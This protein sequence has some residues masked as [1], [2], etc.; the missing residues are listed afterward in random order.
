MALIHPVINHPLIFWLAEK[1][2]MK[3][4]ETQ[5]VRINVENEAHANRWSRFLG[6]LAFTKDRSIRFYQ[7]L[8]ETAAPVRNG[9]PDT[10]HLMNEQLVW[11]SQRTTPYEDNSVTRHIYSIVL[12]EM[13]DSTTST[14]SLHVRLS[15]AINY[16]ISKTSER[17]KPLF[18][19]VKR[20]QPKLVN[21]GFERYTW[22]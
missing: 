9:S 14:S 21:R 4:G 11:R 18:Y 15:Q 13:G 7:R 8:S 5:R 1:R 10:Q 17:G 3:N 2:R 16:S 19:I 22:Q 6:F 20:T 12:P